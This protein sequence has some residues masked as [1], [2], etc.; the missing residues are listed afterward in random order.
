MPNQRDHKY[1]YENSAWYKIY[2]RYRDNKMVYVAN[3]DYL[4]CRDMTSSTVVILVLYFI[5]S[6]VLQLV[7]FKIECVIYLV[8]MFLAT[9]IAT[10]TKGERMVNNVIICD[11]QVRNE[12]EG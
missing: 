8:I 12:N 2:N 3:R 9:N 4:V 10:R 5:F 11:L 6:I 1:R 7:P